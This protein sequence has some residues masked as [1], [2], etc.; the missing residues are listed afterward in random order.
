MHPIELQPDAIWPLS[1][2]AEL[3]GIPPKS[4]TREYRAGRLAGIKRCGRVFVL[5]SDALTWMRST[6]DARKAVRDEK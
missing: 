6:G 3:L 5:G 4:L 2:L 1:D